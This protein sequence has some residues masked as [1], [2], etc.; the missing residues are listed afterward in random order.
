MDFD[1]WFDRLLDSNEIVITKLPVHEWCSLLM[2]ELNVVRLEYLIFDLGG[3]FEH[4]WK[5]HWHR[6]HGSSHCATLPTR[7]FTFFKNQPA[8]FIHHFPMDSDGN[9]ITAVRQP[10]IISWRNSTPKL[11][12]K[13]AIVHR[14]L[15][16]SYYSSLV[17]RHKGRDGV[18]NDKPHDCL[19]KRLFRRRSKKASKL[20]VTGLCAGESPV[21]GEVPAQMVSNAENASIWWRHHISFFVNRDYKREQTPL[22]MVSFDTLYER[23]LHDQKMQIIWQ[24]AGPCFESN[25]TRCQ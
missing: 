21:T 14:Q 18:S 19:L 7:T 20:R 17:W 16:Y 8:C 22:W 10:A 23:S 15:Y 4:D 13:K 5:C 6:E 25:R 3:W 9:N 2:C 1:S 11:N 12:M 24:K